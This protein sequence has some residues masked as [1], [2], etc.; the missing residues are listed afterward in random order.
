MD[1]FFSSHPAP[2]SVDEKEEMITT[3]LLLDGALGDTVAV[4]TPSTGIDASCEG[5]WRTVTRADSHHHHD[6]N[7]W[8]SVDADCVNKVT[9]PVEDEEE[10]DV[11]R[12][13]LPGCW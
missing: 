4:S 2:V 7:L 5:G 10:V 1:S 13:Q 6:L 11:S 8:R 9:L 12:R 3:V